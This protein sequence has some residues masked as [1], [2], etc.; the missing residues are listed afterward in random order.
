LGVLPSPCSTKENNLSVVEELPLR[1]VS[2]LFMASRENYIPSGF[3]CRGELKGAMLSK[4]TPTPYP[5]FKVKN[6]FF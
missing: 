4:R 3:F 5:C 1:A 6:G 2:F